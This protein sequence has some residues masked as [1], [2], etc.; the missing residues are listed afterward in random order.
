MAVS[1]I[2]KYDELY[3][4]I[5]AQCYFPNSTL[6][7]MTITLQTVPSSGVMPKAKF[8]H[9]KKELKRGGECHKKI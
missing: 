4:V 6:K 7:A 5:V 3:P 9:I 1:A 2:R 8:I